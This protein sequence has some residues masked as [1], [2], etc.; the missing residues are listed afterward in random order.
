MARPGPRWS[1]EDMRFLIQMYPDHPAEWV[2]R[3][4]GRPLPAVYAM[5]SKLNLYKSGTFVSSEASGRI[6]KG[7]RLS[8][9]TQFKPGHRTW[10]KGTRFIAGGRAE[11][12]RFKPGRP[13]HEAHNYRPIGSLRLSKDGYLERKVTDDQS[14]APARRWVGVHRLVWIDALGP[15]PPGHSVTFLPGRFTT[16]PEQITPDALELVTRQELMRRNTI[17][18][19]PAELRWTMRLLGKLNKTIEERSK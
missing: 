2:A 6:R 16:D 14:I 8:T 12:T 17:A 15:I 11:Q 13:P 18:R 4:L 19:Y 7:Q 1:E 3:Q 5:A 9:P 10:N